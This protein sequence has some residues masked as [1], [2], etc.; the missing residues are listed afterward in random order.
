MEERRLLL[1]GAVHND[2]VAPAEAEG[3]DVGTG[4]PGF[5]A[6]SNGVGVEREAPLVGEVFVLNEGEAGGEAVLRGETADSDVKRLCGEQ[7]LS[8]VRDVTEG[9]FGAGLGFLLGAGMQLQPLA[10]EVG[11]KAALVAR[12]TAWLIARLRTRGCAP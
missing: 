10:A 12:R 11:M 3:L 7:G 8:D 5:I 6:G 1:A 9:E 4:S 2:D